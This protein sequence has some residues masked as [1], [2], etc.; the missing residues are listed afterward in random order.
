MVATRNDIHQF[1][2]KVLITKPPCDTFIS[3]DCS[4][5]SKMGINRHWWVFGYALLLCIRCF[6]CR[7]RFWCCKLS[8]SQNYWY[9]GG[10]CFCPSVPLWRNLQL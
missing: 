2:I 3:L 10:A 6:N 1:C 8:P 5:P 7:M 4:F 9:F